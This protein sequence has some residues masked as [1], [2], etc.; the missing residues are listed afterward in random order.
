MKSRTDASC[1]APTE[2]LKD[3][4]DPDGIAENLSNQSGLPHVPGDMDNTAHSSPPLAAL[5]VASKGRFE[6][7]SSYRAYCT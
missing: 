6:F 7:C 1:R 3:R 5:R 4:R 2:L